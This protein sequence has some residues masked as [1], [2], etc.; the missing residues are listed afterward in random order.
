MNRTYRSIRNEALSAW[1]ATSEL[2][3]GCH[4]GA[5]RTAVAVAIVLLSMSA[6]QAQTKIGDNSNTINPGSMLEVESTNRGVLITRVALT[7]RSTWTLNGNQ[8]VEGMVVYNTNATTGANGLQA[9]MVVWKG[10]Q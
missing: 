9:G 10:G 5:Q 2:G 1:V 3:C 8:P 4:R 6:A 7:D